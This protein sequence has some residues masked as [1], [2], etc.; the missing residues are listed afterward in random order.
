M[1]LKQSGIASLNVWTS[2]DTWDTKTSAEY[3]FTLVLIC[4]IIEVLQDSAVYA[5]QKSPLL[6]EYYYAA[7]TCQQFA[8]NKMLLML[9][10]VFSI[11][12]IFDIHIR[13]FSRGLLTAY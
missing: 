7:E 5:K 2:F 6:S 9:N 13:F 1:T 10:T 12:K 11:S 4:P 8:A 3:T